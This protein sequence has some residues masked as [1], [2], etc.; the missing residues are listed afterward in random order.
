[1]TERELLFSDVVGKSLDEVGQLW[2]YDRRLPEIINRKYTQ[3][4]T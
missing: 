3:K 4:A 1:M 2:L